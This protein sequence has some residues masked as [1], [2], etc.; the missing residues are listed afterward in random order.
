[1]SSFGQLLLNGNQLLRQ[2]GV[3]SQAASKAG[4]GFADDRVVQAAPLACLLGEA[5]ATRPPPQPQGGV[6]A[7]DNVIHQHV[8]VNPGSEAFARFAQ[9]FQM[10][11]PADVGAE[12]GPAFVAASR[13]VI[14]A[15][16]AFNR[17]ARAIRARNQSAVSTSSP[18]YPLSKL[19][20]IGW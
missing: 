12:D 14:A 13:D 9:E 1:L 8:C 3:G 5:Q 19:L 16:A 11:K 17:K 15:A 18:I 2:S 7:G 4:D 6:A 20:G 10:V